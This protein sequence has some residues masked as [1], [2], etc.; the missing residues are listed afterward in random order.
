MILRF[1][2]ALFLPNSGQETSSGNNP[3]AIKALKEHGLLGKDGALRVGIG[4]D[5]RIRRAYLH[6]KMGSF[7]DQLRN[8]TIYEEA[9]AA[10]IKMIDLK[11]DYPLSVMLGEGV[12]S[13]D[14]PYESDEFAGSDHDI[15]IDKLM[16]SIPESIEE[17]PIEARRGMLEHYVFLV[18]DTPLVTGEDF[19]RDLKGKESITDVLL[20]D[21][22]YKSKVVRAVVNTAV[23]TED[24]AEIVPAILKLGL[25]YNEIMMGG[26]LIGI[27]NIVRQKMRKVAE[28]E[29]GSSDNCLVKAIHGVCIPYALGIALNEYTYDDLRVELKTALKIEDDV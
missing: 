17:I 26:Y 27:L 3:I 29:G 8:A 18:Q 11:I 4:S 14:A 7:L 24:Y 22:D 5:S 13:M 1:L 28:K 19:Y 20:D 25:S 23:E 16:D 6:A 10:C 12:P 15:D 2:K 9:K 21:P